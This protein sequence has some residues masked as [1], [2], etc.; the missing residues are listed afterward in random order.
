VELLATQILEKDIRIR[1]LETTLAPLLSKKKRKKVAIAPEEQFVNI[2]AIK[3]AQEAS[4]AS[5]RLR[6]ERE[7]VYQQKHPQSEYENASSK[8]LD[9]G[10]QNMLFE[11]YL[12]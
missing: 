8:A 3:A 10:Y 12:D 7:E 11:F 5:D 9:Q 1:Q 2:E 6:E 4:K